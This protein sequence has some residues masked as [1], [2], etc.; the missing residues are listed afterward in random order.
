[1]DG[2]ADGTTDGA[3]D[4]AFE[5]GAVRACVGDPDAKGVNVRKLVEILTMVCPAAAVRAPLECSDSSLSTDEAGKVTTSRTLP[6][7][8]A[9]VTDEMGRPSRAAS[10]VRIVKIVEELK[11]S[12]SPDTIIYRV[13]M[14][15]APETGG[16]DGAAVG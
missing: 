2:C 8:M 11:S 3:A 1:M 14:G 16:A 12:T 9:M 10:S 15:P 4:G 7:W 5:G 13:R 6:A